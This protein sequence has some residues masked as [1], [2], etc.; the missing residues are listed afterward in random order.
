MKTHDI[1]VK[2]NSIPAPIQAFSDHE[3]PERVQ[4][5]LQEFEAPTA[6]QAQGWSVALSGK[7]L[8]GIGQVCIIIAITVW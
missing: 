3:F 6:I 2:G 5:L 7:D 4:N 8:I 1:S